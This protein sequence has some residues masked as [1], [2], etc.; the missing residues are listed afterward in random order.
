MT[1]EKSLP[2]I[3]FSGFVISL[4]TQTLINLGNAPDPFTGATHQ[5]LESA[6]QTIDLLAILEDK[7][8][9]NLSPEESA[10]LHKLLLDLRLAYAEKKKA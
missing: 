4:G 6:K 10:L 5:D 8:K 3:D 2:S 9:G 1:E 7:T